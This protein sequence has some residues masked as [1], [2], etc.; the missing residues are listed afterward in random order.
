[1]NNKL[2]ISALFTTLFALPAAADITLKADMGIQ[3]LAHNGQEVT[4]NTL[5][6]DNGT[7]QILVRY[8]IDL[9]RKKD[10]AQL[11]NSDTWV[12]LFKA[13][14]QHIQLSAPR[15]SNAS[16]FR[17]FNR[18][19]NWQLTTAENR[20]V[21]FEKNPLK[22]QGFQFNR[23]YEQEL[24]QF[25]DTDHP[26]AFIASKTE[27]QLTKKTSNSSQKKTPESSQDSADINTEQ[28]LHYWYKSAD[29]NTQIRFKNWLKSQH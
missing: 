4:T 29:K 7:H 15:I 10:N 18:N 2:I 17:Q 19:G 9:S 21:K 24:Q 13:E 12:L 14:D 23:N 11:E 26:A 6:T 5:R 16:Q 25:N 28:M 20:Q 1:M 3:I 8:Q 27:G 22:K